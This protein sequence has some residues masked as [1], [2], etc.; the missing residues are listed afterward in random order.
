M[1]VPLVRYRESLLL[2]PADIQPTQADWEVI[3]AFNPAVTMTDNGPV[4]LARI[5]ERPSSKRTGMTALPRFSAAGLHEIDWI[6][7]SEL[8]PID[9]RVVRLK[10]SGKLRLTSVSYF[11]VFRQR[12]GVDSAWEAS[13]QILPVGDLEE[14]GIE[15]PRIT[16]IDNTYW[17]TYVTVSQSGALTQLISSVD[18]VNF[19]RHGVIFPCEN[20]DVVLFPEM[21]RDQFVALHR[22]N[23]QSQ[24]SAPQIWIAYSPDLIHWGQHN[25]L[26]SGIEQWEADRVGSGPPPILLD[27]GW[28]LLYHGSAKSTLAGAVGCYSVGAVLLDRDAPNQVIAKSTEPLIVPTSDYEVEGFVP[29]VVFPTAT[30]EAGQ[31]LQV[32]YGAADTCVAVLELS[33]Q[34]LLASLKKVSIGDPCHQ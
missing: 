25:P 17:I 13:T 12:A 31:Y 26:L 1:V 32:F 21:L 14:F 20:K 4:M 19:R 2:S 7:D 30:L 10:S 18:M 22:P 16:Q 24:F 6:D 27:E 3:G 28:L 11:G 23:P 15:D 9:A 5:A 33:K 8:Q 29:A 34:D